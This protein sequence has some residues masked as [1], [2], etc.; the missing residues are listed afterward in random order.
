MQPGSA[1]SAARYERPSSAMSTRQRPT[2]ASRMRPSSSSG[3]RPGSAAGKYKKLS[4]CL[5]VQ[6]E[7]QQRRELKHICLKQRKAIDLGDSWTPHPWWHLGGT[8]ITN[9]RVLWLAAQA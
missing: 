8:Q 6:L 1:V 4:F 2:S 9:T 3:Q 7:M 5:N